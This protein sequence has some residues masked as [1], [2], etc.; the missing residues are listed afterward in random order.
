[1]YGFIIA[2]ILSLIG[3]QIVLHLHRGVY[4][5]IETDKDEHILHSWVGKHT[6]VSKSGYHPALVLL[7][8]GFSV[9]LLVVGAII[10][11]FTF[12]YSGMTNYET[13]YSLISIGLHIPETARDSGFMIHS[14]QVFYFILTVG[15]PVM[16]CF[17]YG[18]LF[19]AKVDSVWARR[20]FVLAE[21]ALA[22]SALDVY[23]LSTI[24]AGK[25]VA[26]KLLSY[27]H[28]SH[29]IPTF[30]YMAVAQIPNF[31]KH[32][33]DEYCK[34][35]FTIEA[36]IRPI[37]SLTCVGALV[38]FTI[39]LFLVNKAQKALFSMESVRLCGSNKFNS[40][41]PSAVPV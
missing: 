30:R 7:A 25:L 22:W 11:T 3:T 34:S 16:S 10:D 13:S 38:N 27:T 6:I 29:S 19:F 31:A 9:A 23:I 2:S 39:G 18:I 20:M 33:V 14:L 40:N 15:F 35:C 5:Q 36:K 41:I 12:K 1:M 21:T 28:G 4:R 8:L 24:F 37:F 17:V 32:L 26:L